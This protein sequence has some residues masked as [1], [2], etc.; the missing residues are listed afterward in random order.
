MELKFSKQL[1]ITDNIFSFNKKYERTSVSFL[2]I[3]STSMCEFEK[4]L[5]KK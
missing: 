5:Q 4:E 2:T 3:M 1:F